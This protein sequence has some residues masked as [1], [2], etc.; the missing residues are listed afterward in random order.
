LN[1]STSISDKSEATGLNLSIKTFACPNI[2]YFDLSLVF[3][4]IPNFQSGNCFSQK[5][6]ILAG[7]RSIIKYP[8]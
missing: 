4:Q 7:S 1:L 6:Q 5:L 3:S 8:S 2:S